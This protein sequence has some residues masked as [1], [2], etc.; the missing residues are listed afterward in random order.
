MAYRW[1]KKTMMP[2]VLLASVALGAGC[3]LGTPG[4]NDLPEGMGKVLIRYT[5]PVE[6]RPERVHVFGGDR[7]EGPFDRLTEKPVKVAGRPGE[8]ITL[9]TH[10]PIP[11]GEMRYYYLAEVDADGDLRKIT[12]VVAAEA[13]LPLQPEDAARLARQREKKE[14]P[15]G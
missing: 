7:F 6:N 10:L 3:G 9:W 12:R 13:L 15:E 5:V 1:T 4:A 11:L 8:T 14:A 2:F